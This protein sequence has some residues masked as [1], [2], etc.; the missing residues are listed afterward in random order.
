MPGRFRRGSYAYAKDGRKYV[1]ED[2]EDGIVY[3]SSDSGAETE[4]PETALQNE[5]EWGSRADGRRDLA[6]TKLKQARAYAQPIATL[7]RAA[8]QETL[9][10]V[11]R[12]EPGLLDFVAF[13]V[14]TRAL[15]ESGSE[16]LLVGLSIAKCR[17]I[18]DAARPDVRAGL[19]SVLLDAPPAAL[20]SAGRLGDNLMRAMLQKGLARHEAAFDAFRDRRRR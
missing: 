15:T 11:E 4:F 16:D 10:K 3:C 17:E 7:D 8:S 9:T 18:F 5:A 1:V 19:L 6:Y 12:L 14:A 20:V 13:T 2:V